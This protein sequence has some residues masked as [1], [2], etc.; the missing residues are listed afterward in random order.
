MEG[1]E[2]SAFFLRLFNSVF[3]RP[4]SPIP[5]FFESAETIS[6]G[7]VHLLFEVPETSSFCLH[8]YCVTNPREFL[9][10]EMLFFVWLLA[11]KAEH[12]GKSFLGSPDSNCSSNIL[13]QAW[14]L[15]NYSFVLLHENSH[16]LYLMMM[17]SRPR[18]THTT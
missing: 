7:G 18:Q 10:S 9:I 5:T 1:V 2:V 12:R 6:S 14:R 3:G 8:T 11:N 16:F 4:S 15:D 13:T 17:C